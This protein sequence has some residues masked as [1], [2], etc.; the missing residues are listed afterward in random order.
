[1]M[2]GFAVLIPVE[3]ELFDKVSDF[4]S[5]V[6]GLS[7][8][9][10]GESDLGNPW[11]T[12]QVPGGTTITIHTGRDGKFPYPE[13][14]P[15]GHGVAFALEVSSLGEMKARLRSKEVE[16]LNTWKY[17]DGTEAIS[18]ADPAGNVSELWG[19]K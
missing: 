4:Y 16:P 6:L 2:C 18:I 9:E 19:R 8:L 12:L 17:K 15:T 1:M 10:S 13:F 11:W 7:L 3:Y 5:N 14:R